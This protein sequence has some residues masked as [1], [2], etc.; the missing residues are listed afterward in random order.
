MTIEIQ[1]SEKSKSYMP[2]TKSCNLTN[3]A[4]FMANVAIQQP[5]AR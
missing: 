4:R 3:F 5:D 2:E 1:S